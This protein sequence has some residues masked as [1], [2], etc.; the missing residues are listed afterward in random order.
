MFKKFSAAQTPSPH[1]SRRDDDRIKL[2]AASPDHTITAMMRSTQ[3][4][5]TATEQAI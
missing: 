2:R 1:F 5:A 4:I 3:L